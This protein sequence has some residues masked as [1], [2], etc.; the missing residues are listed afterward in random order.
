M[1]NKITFDFYNLKICIV[2]LKNSGPKMS[3][4]KSFTIS[5]MYVIKI[6]VRDSE[7]T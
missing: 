3:N 2:T 5:R 1:R 6:I 7:S 4:V